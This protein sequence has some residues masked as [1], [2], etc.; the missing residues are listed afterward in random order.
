MN[1]V[2]QTQQVK[3]CIGLM[4]NG[5]NYSD[6][7]CRDVKKDGGKTKH[8]YLLHLPHI[9]VSVD[10]VLQ[11]QWACINRYISKRKLQND[12]SAN[13]QKWSS[14]AQQWSV[15]SIHYTHTQCND[16][17]SM[18]MGA[19]IPQ[20]FFAPPPQHLFLQF[21]KYFLSLTLLLIRWLSRDFREFRVCILFYCVKRAVKHCVQR[22]KKNRNGNMILRCTWRKKMNKFVLSLFACCCCRRLFCSCYFL[23]FCF[24]LLYFLFGGFILAVLCIRVCM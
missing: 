12:L 5:Q 17:V 19:W 13:S 6:H 1:V 4:V 16:F 21:F 22:W 14:S 20:D 2:T 10:R 23:W 8:F 18:A 24:A 11:P 9:A 3:C 15:V 7:W